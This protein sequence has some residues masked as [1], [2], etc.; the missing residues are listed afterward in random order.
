MTAEPTP[1]PDVEVLLAST[2]WLRM[3]ALRLLHDQ[4]DADDVVQDT[5]K[6]ALERPPHADTPIRPWLAR[7]ARNLSL[8]TI[9]TKERR[10]RRD[11]AA[12]AP[13]SELT[14]D[15]VLLRAEAFRLLAEAVVS[16]EA[17]YREVVVLRYLDELSIAEVAARLG[18]PLETARTRLRRAIETL[19]VRLDAAHEG[20]RDAWTVPLLALSRGGS[21]NAPVPPAGGGIAIAAAAAGGGAVAGI[22]TK[23]AIAAAVIATLIGG[24]WYVGQR[25]AAPVQH[26]EMAQAA[27]GVPAA[28]RPRIRAGG[29]E[30]SSAADESP[31][32]FPSVDRDRDLHGRVVDTA[33]R[34]IAHA[35]VRAVRRPWRDAGFQSP[36]A[37]QREGESGPATTTDVE[38][39]FA[40]RLRPGEVVDLAVTAQGFASQ[41]LG[42][43]AAGERVTVTLDAGVR[44]LV[45][46]RGEDGAAVPGATVDATEP[47]GP[48]PGLVLHAKAASDA[49]GRAVFAALPASRPLVV[50]VSHPEFLPADEISLKLPATGEL[51]ASVALTAGRAVAGRVLDAATAQLLPDADV[52]A[53]PYVPTRVGPDASFRIRVRPKEPKFLVRAP[54]HLPQIVDPGEGTNLDIRLAAANEVR[55]RVVDASGA[56]IDAACIAARTDRADATATSGTDGRFV[57]DGLPASTS[58]SLWFFAPGHGRILFAAKTPDTGPLDVGDVRLPEPRTIAGR[59]TGADGTPIARAEVL[60]L[61]RN[62]DAE[63]RFSADWPPPAPFSFFPRIRTDDLGRFRFTELAAGEWRVEARIPGSDAVVRMVQLAADADALDVDLAAQRA[64]FTAHVSDEAGRPVEGAVL[65]VSTGGGQRRVVTDASGTVTA[66]IGGG[67]V[68]AWVDVAADDGRALRTVTRPKDIG[69]AREASFV[70]REMAWIKGRVE[71]EDGK[72][73]EGELTCVGA[74]GAHVGGARSDSSGTFRVAVEPGVTCDV[75]FSAWQPGSRAAGWGGGVAG[76]VAGG[77]PVIVKVGP[78]AATATLTLRTLTSDGEPLAGVQVYLSDGRGNAVPAIATS[79]A[80][81]RIRWDAVPARLWELQIDTGGPTPPAWRTSGWLEPV[82]FRSLRPHGQEIVLRFRRAGTAEGRV[83]LPPGWKGPAYVAAYNGDTCVSSAYARDDGT[84]TIPLPLDVS[85]PFRVAFSVRR[86]GDGKYAEGEATGVHPGDTGVRV[87]VRER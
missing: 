8:R 85:G 24:V 51:A 23:A 14:P 59:V 6:A 49:E 27:T 52:F 21:G 87:V 18:V 86:I 2:G 15:A 44:L 60:L 1:S 10:R 48:A 55:G 70:V 3:L 68:S 66:E 69:M 13:S 58:L 31:D 57:L 37:S 4:D 17:P 9:R 77:P 28:Q 63:R 39:R 80:D 38:G 83:E 79:D 36:R 22:G 30:A 35:D 65:Y 33:A 75:E 43:V 53:S 64:T 5:L 74:D 40:L 71:D 82:G 81:G 72:S 16:L 54:G 56:P 26:G 32:A 73:V 45:N 61:G 76:A 20:R 11:I 50:R 25:P 7:V 12:A 41:T 78:A 62:A 47:F 34:P 46:V 67:T 19:R 42:S 29:R 84:F